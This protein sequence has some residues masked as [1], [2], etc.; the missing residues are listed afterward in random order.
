MTD[1]K[2]PNL[3]RKYQLELNKL[4]R[5]HQRGDFTPQGE[6]EFQRQREIVKAA[7]DAIIRAEQQQ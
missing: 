7:Y 5:L 3:Y 1:K 6:F 4:K 2:L